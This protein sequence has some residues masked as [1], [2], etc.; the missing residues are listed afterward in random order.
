MTKVMTIMRTVW[1]GPPD[2]PV[3]AR[4]R[5]DDA[6]GLRFCYRAVGRGDADCEFSLWAEVGEPYRR[7]F[8]E[9]FALYELKDHV[10]YSGPPWYADT[11][12]RKG[13][14]DR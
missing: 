11:A 12:E 4:V 2:H 6:G 7:Y 3:R 1:S 14:A 10:E 9:F 8:D 13:H 5:R